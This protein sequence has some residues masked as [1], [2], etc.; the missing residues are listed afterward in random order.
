MVVSPFKGSAAVRP[1]APVQ[2]VRARMVKTVGQKPRARMVKISRSGPAR[3]GLAR[4][5]AK[6]GHRSTNRS[7]EHHGLERV[8]KLSVLD[9]PGRG[10]PGF[11]PKVDVVVQTVVK[12]IMVLSGWQNCPFWTS[13][14]GVGQD[15][16]QKWTS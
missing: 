12:H 11:G 3:K 8:A 6:S 2:T 16:G 5:L 9:Q 7:K 4:I 15:F 14:E 10:W 1:H 13:L